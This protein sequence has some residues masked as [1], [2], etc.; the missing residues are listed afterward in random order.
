MAARADGDSAGSGTVAR[1]RLALSSPARPRQRASIPASLM[2][3]S[4]MTLRSQPLPWQVMTIHWFGMSAGLTAR[5]PWQ[6]GHSRFWPPLGVAGRT[7]QTWLRWQ[8]A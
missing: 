3:L 8:N 6:A 7:P 1:P 5:L 4:R 2:S